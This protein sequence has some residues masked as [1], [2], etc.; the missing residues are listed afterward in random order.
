MN[1]RGQSFSVFELMI[2]GVVAFAILVILLTILGPFPFTPTNNPVTEISN[3]IKT[4]SPSGETTTSDFTLQKDQSVDNTD[5]AVKA[6]LDKES[7][8]FAV[9]LLG[10]DQSIMVDS[11][12]GAS[13]V[14]Y[15]GTLSKK[16]AARVICKQTAAGLTDALARLGSEYQLG[17]ASFC[18]EATPC[19]AVVLIRPRQ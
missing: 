6:N 9:G 19:C 18:G 10:S 15:T 2:A 4:A 3:A 13:Y 16:I 7:I 17:D 5:I 8:F 12:N 14:K 1:E 11:S